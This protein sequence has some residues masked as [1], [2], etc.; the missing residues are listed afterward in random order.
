MFLR[1]WA[2]TPT[3]EH[4]TTLQARL[5][6]Y[7]ALKMTEA[8]RGK[9]LHN[10]GEMYIGQATAISSWLR[11]FHESRLPPAGHEDVHLEQR[12]AVAPV[13]AGLQDTPSSVQA[14]WRGRTTE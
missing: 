1:F 2:T 10:Y 12:P 7:A 8:T 5:N 9:Q 4:M 11:E 14:R 3:S 13:R 6:S